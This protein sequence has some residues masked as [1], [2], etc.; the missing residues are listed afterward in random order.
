MRFPSPLIPATLVRRYKR[1]LADVL[2][3]SGEQITVHVANPGA[4]TGLATPGARVFLSKSSNDRRKLPY[5]WELVEADVG[6]GPELIGVNTTH[7]NGLVMEAISTSQIP[8]LTGYS[9]ISREV[10]YGR[11]SR[12]DFLLERPGSAAC[13]LEVKN[14]HLMRQ[15]RLAEFP[16]AVTKRGARHLAELGVHDW[17]RGAGRHAVSDPDRLGGAFHA[18]S[19]H[20]SRLR[21]RLRPCAATRGRGPGLALHDR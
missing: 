18:C 20:R 14:V 8:E 11:Q 19:R 9:R 12:I 3:N 2:L 10:S 15:A 21:D 16:D 6:S 7:P 17:Q 5:S 4:M 13:Y 1:F